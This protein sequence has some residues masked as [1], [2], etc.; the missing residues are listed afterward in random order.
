MRGPHPR[1]RKKNKE[2]KRADKRQPHRRVV[3]IRT[4][5]KK[6]LVHQRG[7]RKRVQGKKVR[8]MRRPQKKHRGKK[9]SD[10]ADERTERTWRLRRVAHTKRRCNGQRQTRFFFLVWRFSARC[11]RSRS[12]PE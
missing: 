6:M 3:N 11:H 1:E 2:R 9:N 10:D 8:P 5:H 12:G 4:W 7:I